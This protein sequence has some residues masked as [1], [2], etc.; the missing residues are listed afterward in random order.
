[1]EN[2]EEVRFQRA[3]N[4]HILCSINHVLL[5]FLQQNSAVLPSHSVI[6]R[7]VGEGERWIP[8]GTPSWQRPLVMPQL[9][10]GTPRS[11]PHPAGWDLWPRAGGFVPLCS[12][13]FET[14]LFC[15]RLLFSAL[16]FQ[17]LF[18][19]QAVKRVKKGIVSIMVIKLPGNSLIR[20]IKSK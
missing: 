8:A 17:G 2:D 9:T 12:D 7:A 10:R 13:W 14:P 19:F 18:L 6:P 1:M 4:P 3:G 16:S 20:L 11:R 15:W 5:I